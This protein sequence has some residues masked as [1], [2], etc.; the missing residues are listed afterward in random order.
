MVLSVSILQLLVTMTCTNL[1][2]REVGAGRAA[3]EALWQTAR[4]RGRRVLHEA[5]VGAGLPV[6]DGTQVCAAAFQGKVACYEIQTRNLTWSRDISSARDL[7]RD[8]KNIYVVDDTSAVH[9]LDKTS[10]ASLCRPKA[11]PPK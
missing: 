10:G 6:I 9:A 1:A 3:S 5:T 4:A 7:A 11:R 8:V 2:L